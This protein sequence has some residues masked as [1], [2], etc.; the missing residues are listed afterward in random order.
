MERVGDGR[1]FVIFELFAMRALVAQ[2]TL[3]R[4]GRELPCLELCMAGLTGH[5]LVRAVE[6]EAG[7]FMGERGRSEAGSGMASCAGPEITMTRHLVT[8]LAFRGR[9]FED[10][11]FGVAILTAHNQVLAGERE[12][13]LAIV[14]KGFGLER[15]CGVAA[16]AGAEVVVG[17]V[18]EMAARADQRCGIEDEIGMTLDTFGGLVL[19]GEDAGAEIVGE[20]GLVPV[21][22]VVTGGAGGLGAAVLLFMTVAARK[23][24]GQVSAA[25]VAGFAL[26]VGVAADH[27]NLVIG[28]GKRGR[29]EGCGGMTARAVLAECALMCPGIVLFVAANATGR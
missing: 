10:I 3:V 9:A 14:I 12:F 5:F 18:F 2:H 4:T 22:G 21:S 25:L 7:L 24:F 16:G 23:C 26:E 8:A 19:A 11:L 17:A 1:N 13:G 28:N 29:L 6:R 20:A 27:G 15:Q